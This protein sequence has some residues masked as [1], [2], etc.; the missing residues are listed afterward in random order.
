[1]AVVGFLQD[2]AQRVV[3][4]LE[5]VVERKQGLSQFASQEGK[6]GGEFYTPRDVVRLMVRLVDPQPGMRIYDPCVGSGGMLITAKRPA[7][8]RSS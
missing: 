2:D 3:V 8:M 4:E 6:K 7:A 5:Q 1:M